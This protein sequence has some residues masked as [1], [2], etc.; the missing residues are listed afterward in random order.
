LIHSI[1]DGLSDYYRLD[2]G[3]ILHRPYNHTMYTASIKNA[4]NQTPKAK[5]KQGIQSEK[6]PSSS[7][8][9]MPIPHPT[10]FLMDFLITIV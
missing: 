4:V 1:L 8:I 2:M 7:S 3:W 6:Y 5:A 10:A 9:I